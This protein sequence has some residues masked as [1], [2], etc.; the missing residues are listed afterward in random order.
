MKKVFVL[1]LVCLFTSVLS[2]QV[3]AKPGFRAGANFSNF[4]HTDFDYRTDFY[5]GGFVAL[6]LNNFYAIQPEINYSRQGAAANLRYYDNGTITSFEKDIEIEYLS[7]VFINRFSF[8]NVNMHMGPTFDIELNSSV[9]TNIDFDM[10]VTMGIGYTLPMGLTI[11]ARW[12]RG[13]FDVLE[14]DDYN[15]TINTV[16]D[17]NANNVFQLGLAYSFKAKGASK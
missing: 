14:T 4:S 16:G 10:G 6:Q 7:M 2:A 12:K 3:T 11:E 13:L 1:M 8:Y 15:G 17:N 5:V 9:P